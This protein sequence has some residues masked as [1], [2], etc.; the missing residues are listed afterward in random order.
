MRRI[1][2]RRL[3]PA[4]LATLAAAALFACAPVPD[5]APAAK[6]EIAVSFDEAMSAEPLDGRV[7]VML[8]TDDSDEPRFQISAGV[9]SMQVFG[10]DVEDLAPGA[11]AV[12]DSATFGYPAAR[13][14]ELAPGEYRV[15]ALLH[16]YETFERADGHTLK[17]PMDRGEGQRWNKAPGNLYSTPTTLTVDPSKRTGWYSCR[18]GSA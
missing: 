5:D 15:Q 7:L 9:K 14:A 13:L 1:N 12:V 3:D 4:L 6:I 10:V 11:E 2:D 18:P 16:R 8:S 17:L